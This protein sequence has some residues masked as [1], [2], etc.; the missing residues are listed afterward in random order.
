MKEADLSVEDWPHHLQP[1]L[2]GKALS[3]YSKNVP[4]QARLNY[5]DIKEALL[6]SLGLTV[7]QCRNEFWVLQRK[8]GETWQDT[9]RKIDSMVERMT[10]D[11]SS[12]KEVTDMNA[13]HTFYSLCPTDCVDYA[14]LHHPKATVEAA[15]LIYEYQP[16][17]NRERKYK[18]WNRFG[19]NNEYSEER[20]RIDGNGGE[21]PNEKRP[22]FG[23][24]YDNQGTRGSTSEQ[25]WVP[26]CFGCGKHGHKVNVCPERK[27]AGQANIKRIVA[28]YLIA[29]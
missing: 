27:Q 15:N 17:H 2:T 25:V 5:Y 4:E 22:T 7:E 3:A 21:K 18:S 19:H 26:T 6:S 14:R 29:P 20:K 24:S 23:K 9:A 8:Y 28:P 13:M 1:L 12:I 11:C 10:H 16:S